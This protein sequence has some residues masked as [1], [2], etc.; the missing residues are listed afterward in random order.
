MFAVRPV[1]GV[2]A[3]RAWRRRRDDARRARALGLLHSTKPNSP[4]AASPFVLVDT[5]PGTSATSPTSSRSRTTRARP[6]CSPRTGSTTRRATST[7]GLMPHGSSTGLPV[8]LVIGDHDPPPRERC[9]APPAR[10]RNASAAGFHV[11]AFVPPCW[12]RPRRSSAWS[13][14]SR[15]RS[16]SSAAAALE[17]HLDVARDP[18]PSGRSV[19]AIA[20]SRSVHC[21]WA[22]S[23]RCV[24]AV[25]AGGSTRPRSSGVNDART[26]AS[27]IL[28]RFRR[29][30]D[31]VV[32]VCAAT[33][34]P[35]D[36][37]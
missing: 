24:P 37:S 4:L 34:P 14:S 21:S 3:D 28:S 35:D 27:A 32:R 17:P 20:S 18:D 15:C 30:R 19:A 36:V 10:T 11:V 22:T 8:L 9:A 26:G 5:T 29:R 13:S 31:P 12:C 23:P 6:S 25:S 1:S 33:A 2:G 7:S 16:A